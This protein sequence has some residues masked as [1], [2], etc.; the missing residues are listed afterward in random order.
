M[1][2]KLNLI[3]ASLIIAC[4]I[5]T[6]APNL[7]LAPTEAALAYVE[8]GLYTAETETLSLI[9]TGQ[10]PTA[11][12]RAV[13]RVGGH[14]SSELWLIDA[15][16]ATVPAHQLDILQRI[17]TPLEPAANIDLQQTQEADLIIDG[18][19][20]YSLSGAPR[21]AAA[22]L[23]QWA[24]QQPAP[25]LALDTPSGLDATPGVIFDPAIRVT[26]SISVIRS[27]GL[28]GVSI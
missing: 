19:I 13:E 27:N 17:H 7:A 25:I 6:G 12:A 26:A 24:N 21:G 8:P 2:I 5:S 16:A 9:V 15:V 3:L 20:G 10:D 22:D 23:V 14:I 18:I 1:N 11:A 28:E 4:L